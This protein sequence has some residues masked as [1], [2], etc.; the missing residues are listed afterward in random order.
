MSIW[1]D[2]FNWEGDWGHHEALWS[3]RTHGA[4]HG[5][6][7][8]AYELAA[9]S[10]T[11]EA[12]QHGRSGFD[13]L[14]YYALF[15]QEGVQWSY[16]ASCVKVSNQANRPDAI[17]FDGVS[18]VMAHF[19]FVALG[20]SH[21]V[22]TPDASFS[23][24][25]FNKAIQ[26]FA[27]IHTPCVLAARFDGNPSHSTWVALNMCTH[28][29]ETAHPLKVIDMSWYVATDE[30]GWVSVNDISS[31]DEPPW[32]NGPLDV[33]TQAFAEGERLN[34]VGPLTLNFITVPPHHG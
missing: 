32:D 4:L 21:E 26:G 24:Q 3:D 34:S 33:H 6:L 11:A 18:Q 9:I 25:H 30:G 7:W 19:N 28:R 15:R 29:A 13:V 2:E 16:W 12:Q 17:E 31:L 1:L 20:S 23:T 5:L 27:A 10:I 8:A 22:V 14:A